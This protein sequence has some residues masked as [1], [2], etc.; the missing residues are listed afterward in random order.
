MFENFWSREL[1]ES[2]LPVNTTNDKWQINTSPKTE[3]VWRVS[4]IHP[5]ASVSII[6][7]PLLIPRGECGEIAWEEF[8][9]KMLSSSPGLTA[10][11]SFTSSGGGPQTKLN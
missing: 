8:L 9:Y 1:C 5:K 6:L 3:F 10:E 7:L 11:G 4:D 2:C